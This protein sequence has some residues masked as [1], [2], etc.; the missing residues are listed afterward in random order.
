MNFGRD[1]TTS[2]G[3]PVRLFMSFAVVMLVAVLLLRLVLAPSD[4]SEANRRGLAQGQSEAV[5]MAQTAIGP[6]LDGRP[7]SKGLSA[8]ENA[9]M[10]R[11]V[12]VAFSSHHILRLRLRDLSG[13]VVFSNDG[14]G[15]RQQAN[16][17]NRDEI[18]SA[19]IGVVVARVTRLNADNAYGALGPPSV[20]VY[21]PL[22]AGTS[23]HRVGILEMYLPYTPISLDVN[24]GLNSLYWNLAL[25]LGALY[26]LLFIISYIVSGKLR[27]QVKISAHLAE[28][29]ALT[30]LPNRMLFHRHA[31]RA[32]ERD[33]RRGA[34]TIIAIVD[35][36]R[37][38]E[39]NDTLGHH[40]GDRLLRKLSENM[41]AFLK[42]PTA[43][44]RLGGDEF[45]VLLSGVEKPE[46]VLRQLRSVIEGEIVIG[47][48][49]LSLEAS[50]GFALSPDHA[51]DVDELLQLADV[52]MYS[53]KK[54]HAGVVRYDPSQNHYD[55]GNL[56]LIAELRQ[57][58][59]TGQLLLHY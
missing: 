11:L 2:R 40:N 54:T 59:D 47:D 51:T 56:T 50:I 55:A 3:S 7:L 1:S 34:T 21:L 15:L 37:F 30:D 52:A 5:I 29:D 53:A 12:H 25:G 19:A 17:D 49:P 38:K 36:D 22:V 27:R 10:K 41:T 18:L 57:A 9:D 43:L 42:E 44:A 33:A 26:I 14:T 31:Q 28:H 13:T 32:L 35:L 48:L 8:A 46:N 58:I 16:N 20:E 24:A 23:D 45:G 6:L 39:I 4:R